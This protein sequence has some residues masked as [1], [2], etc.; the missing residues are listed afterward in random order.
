MTNKAK[1]TTPPKGT[2]STR[3]VREKSGFFTIRDGGGSNP[4]NR[5]P[6]EQ[7]TRAIETLVGKSSK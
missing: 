2:Q 4:Q 3:L 6:Q 7:L 1:G 5:T